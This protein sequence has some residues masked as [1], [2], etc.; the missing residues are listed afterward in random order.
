MKVCSKCKVEKEFIE[1]YK[2]K[3]GKNGLH[4]SCKNCCKQYNKQYEL[5]NKENRKEYNKQYHIDNKQQIKQYKKEN[6]DKISKYQKQYELDNKENRKEYH[7]K[8]RIDN[9]ERVNIRQKNRME[10]DYLFKLIC[11]TRNLIRISIKGKG[12]SK[13]SKTY[14]ILGCSFEDFKQHLESQFTEGMTWENQGVWHLDH[15][16]PVSLAT[17]EQHL[18][19]LNHY[20]NFQPLWAEDNIKKSNKL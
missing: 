18:I 2:H 16:Y 17:D 9:K 6:I 3:K 1:F 15:V 13:K 4:P 8:Y 11:N 12:Y 5:D 7:I 20:T 10:T 14:K 19:K